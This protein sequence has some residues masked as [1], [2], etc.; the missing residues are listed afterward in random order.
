MKKKKKNAI[1]SKI[2]LMSNFS[3]SP[4]I[5]SLSLRCSLHTLF[6][7]YRC[8]Q[9]ADNFVRTFPFESLKSYYFEV[10]A[11]AILSCALTRAAAVNCS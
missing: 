2:I 7:A 4:P 8:A 9:S 3:S 5:L 6:Y 10:F 11:A 1:T